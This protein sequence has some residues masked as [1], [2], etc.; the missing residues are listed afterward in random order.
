MCVQ[1]IL[2]AHARVYQLFKSKYQGEIGITVDASCYFADGQNGDMHERAMQFHL[3]YILNPF[4]IGGYPQIMVDTIRNNSLREER[5]FSRLPEMTLQQI[6]FIKGSVDFIGLNYMTS[7]MV[8]SHSDTNIPAS[9]PS[10]S[11]DAG[12]IEHGNPLWKQSNAP[13]LFNVPQGLRAVLKW[14][15]DRYNNPK[16][17]ITENGWSDEGGTKDYDRIAYFNDHLNA[18]ATAIDEDKCN[19]IG[20]FAKSLLDSFEWDAGYKYKFGLFQVERGKNSTFER[21]P[22]LSVS[23]WKKFLLTGA[24]QKSTAYFQV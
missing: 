6:D 12:I 21:K 3:G 9:G 2:I 24:L 13:W 14:I 16:V 4:F 11:S 8:Q 23:Y 20:Y 18:V 7:S 15:K 5:R 17:M 22:K 1:N 19:V 10:W